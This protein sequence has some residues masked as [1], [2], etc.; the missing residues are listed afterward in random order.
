LSTQTWKSTSKEREVRKRLKKASNLNIALIT[1]AGKG[2]GRDVALLLH[3]CGATVVAI[4]RSKEDL[5][6]LQ[7]EIGC[8]TIVADL[9]DSSGH[10]FVRNSLQHNKRKM[11]PKKLEKLICL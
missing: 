2:I 10:L 9:S 11:Q 6:L 7:K 3:E 8:E 4:S 5:D 1:G